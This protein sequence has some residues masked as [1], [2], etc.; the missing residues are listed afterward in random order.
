MN[1]S[2]EKAT[3]GQLKRLSWN[4]VKQLKTSTLIFTMRSWLCLLYQGIKIEA[5]IFIRGDVNHWDNCFTFWILKRKSS[6]KDHYDEKKHLFQ[7]TLQPNDY[8]KLEFGPWLSW[9]HFSKNYLLPW[10]FQICYQRCGNTWTMR[11]WFVGQSFATTSFAS[12][13]D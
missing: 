11:S 3:D 10:A 6:W 8:G 7:I 4:Q 2:L 1:L 13:R 9:C 5:W 12:E